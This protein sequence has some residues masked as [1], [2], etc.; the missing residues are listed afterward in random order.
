MPSSNGLIY[1]AYTKY[2]IRLDASQYPHSHIFIWTMQRA[3]SPRYKL[4]QIDIT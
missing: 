4:N 1:Y 2:S 3:A